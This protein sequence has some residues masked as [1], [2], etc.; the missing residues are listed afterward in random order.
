MNGNGLRWMPLCI[1]ASTSALLAASAGSQASASQIHKLKHGESVFSIARK[2][3][4]SVHA[5]AEANPSLDVDSVPDGHKI[6][7]PDVSA[8]S[9]SIKSAAHK[10]AVA[11]IQVAS[12]HHKIAYTLGDHVGLRVG[13]GETFQRIGACWKGEKLVV[14]GVKDGWAHVTAANGSS[15]WMRHDFVKYAHGG[16][17]VT[18]IAA[19]SKKAKKAE[20]LAAAMHR[21]HLRHLAALATQSHRKHAVQLAHAEHHA[22][23][24]KHHL[25]SREHNRGG[26]SSVVGTAIAYRGTPYRYGST[27]GGSFD[28]SGFTRFV[29]SRKGVSLPHSAK[30]QFQQGHSV[31]RSELKPGDLVFFHTVTSGISH[32]G[33]YAGN[34]KFVHASSR[35]SGGVRVDRLDSG[36][37]SSAFRGAR[38]VK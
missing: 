26:D 36:Y 25:A 21:E 8:K 13:P 3:H 14:T 2:Y 33:I 32:V 34:G 10:T 6:V 38:R 22:H 23:G 20:A 9:V 5:I 19:H 15:G 31:S 1:S 11:K 7:I 16:V 4:V 12:G 17:P 29:Y 37:Y 18:G 27:G 24:S 28:C 35:R 30:E